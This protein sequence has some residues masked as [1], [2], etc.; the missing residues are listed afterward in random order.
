MHQRERK[1]DRAQDKH[2]GI[3]QDK[4]SVK[5]GIGESK[6][7]SK[8]SAMGD[9]ISLSRQSEEHKDDKH[10]PYEEIPPP[11]S[12]QAS[13]QP[14]NS[15]RNHNSNSQSKR[16]LQAPSSSVKKSNSKASGT[17]TAEVE[18]WELQ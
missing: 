3:G 2:S 7:D 6:E 5:S 16:Q 14:Q 17:K 18:E 12:P 8:L 13:K 15:T 4:D 10:H 1:T 11:Q 9:K